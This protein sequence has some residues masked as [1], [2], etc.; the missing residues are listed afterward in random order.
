ML[1]IFPLKRNELDKLV[2]L[3]MHPDV[4]KFVM[5][6][7][8]EEH[9][10]NIQNI[11]LTYLKIVLN[12]QFLGYV[13]LNLDN[14]HVSVELRRIAIKDRCNGIGQEALRL[15]ENYCINELDRSR[16]WLD[17]FS[18]NTIARHVYEKFGYTP[19]GSYIVEDSELVLY[20]KKFSYN[21]KITKKF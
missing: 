8:L 4:S 16:I 18:E 5:A 19:F 2:E 20:D 17:V 14:D 15:I 12:D 9:Q 13:I 3:E 7:T 11:N 10:K 21:N 6:N 1:N